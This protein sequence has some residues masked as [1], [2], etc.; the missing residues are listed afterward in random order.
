MTVRGAGLRTP[1]LT[2]IGPSASLHERL[3]WFEGRPL[4]GRRVLVTR[5][6]HQASALADL[7]RR[8][9]ASPIE[10]PTIELAPVASSTQILRTTFE[11]SNVR[12]L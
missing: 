4:F 12:G 9:G 8:E 5:A 3:N 2:V 10:L 11:L 7:L 6:R 1:L